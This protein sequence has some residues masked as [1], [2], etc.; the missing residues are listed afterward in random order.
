M[1]PSPSKPV[2]SG[3]WSVVSGQRSEAHKKKPARPARPARL[4]RPGQARDAQPWSPL[5]IRDNLEPLG[6][7]A[8]PDVKTAGANQL[9]PLCSLTRGARED[10]LFAT[11]PLVNPRMPPV[12][13]FSTAVRPPG[14]GLSGLSGQVR[15][16]YRVVSP[17]RHDRVGH[18]DGHDNKGRSGSAS[19]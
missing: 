14:C 6:R 13:S 1:C 9:K 19:R 16:I 4:A 3:H 15:I 18:T 10:S 7:L 2:A 11:P 17:R 5:P 12:V 8:G